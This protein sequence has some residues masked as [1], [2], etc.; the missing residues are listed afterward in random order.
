M[1]ISII[2]K[3]SMTSNSAPVVTTSLRG[4]APSFVGN[5]DNSAM[6]N[7][8]KLAGLGTDYVATP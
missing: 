1:K 6:Y 2:K 4:G 3:Q 7:P 8:A 5:I